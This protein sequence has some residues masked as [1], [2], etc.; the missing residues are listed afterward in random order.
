V[1]QRHRQTDDRQTTDGRLI[2]RS[3]KRN[4]LHDY[5]N[6]IATQ[7]NSCGEWVNWVRLTSLNGLCRTLH[8]QPAR[9]QQQ[10]RNPA[11]EA[12]DRRRRDSDPALSVSAV[13]SVRVRCLW[14]T[15]YSRPDNSPRHLRL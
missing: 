13:V 8:R 11:K 6:A 7:A 14:P 10:Q 2:G 4:V 3:L 5:V 15:D 9:Q 1:H 12:S